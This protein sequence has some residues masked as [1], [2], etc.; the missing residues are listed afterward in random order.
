MHEPILFVV[1]GPSGSGK[2]TI[3]RAIVKQYTNI[4]KIATYTTRPPRANEEHGFDY[5]FISQACFLKKVSAGEIA[6][7]EQVYQ[8]HY[9]GSPSFNPDTGPDRLMELDYKGMFKYKAL[10]KRLVSIF[11]APPS[12]E[13]M[14]ERIEKRSTEANLA[15]RINNAIDQMRYAQHY[16][17]II[18]NAQMD[19]ACAEAVAIVGAERARRDHR[20][21]MAALDALCRTRE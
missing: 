7:W 3:M 2:G 17:Y 16:D 15:N 8:D 20:Q 18:I 13:E 11:V 1:T 6:E 21:R 5:N 12:L 9:Y 10:A 4:V 14:V 19:E